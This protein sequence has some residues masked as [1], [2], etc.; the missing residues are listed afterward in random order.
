MDVSYSIHRQRHVHTDLIW[1]REEIDRRTLQREIL[2]RDRTRSLVTSYIYEYTYVDTSLSLYAYVMWGWS[3]E[4]VWRPRILPHFEGLC[5]WYGNRIFLYA[6]F[7]S[8]LLSF[9]FRY[10]F[11]DN[12]QAMSIPGV[13]P[14]GYYFMEYLRASLLRLAIEMIRLPNSTLFFLMIAGA[15]L[16]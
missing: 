16:R 1:Y 2:G 6:F 3:R 9:V 15:C 14:S 8:F 10:E 13:D 5:C 4:C 7:L 12:V 11:T